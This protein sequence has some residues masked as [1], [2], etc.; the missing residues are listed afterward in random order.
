MKDLRARLGFGTLLIAGVVAIFWFDRGAADPWP[1]V[2]V[3]GLLSLAALV[4]CC[5]MLAAA[6]L[7]PQISA[8]LVLGALTLIGA[9]LG[10]PRTLGV[11]LPLALY[12]VFEVLRREPKLAVQRL[13]GT[14]L[15][16]A[17]VPLL[18]AEAI[19][20]R[21]SIPQGWSWL[22]FLVAVCKVGD[23]CAYLVGTAFGR[24]K[25]IPEVSPNKSW[26]GAVAS[27]V[28][29]VLAAAVVVAF[30]FPVGAAPAFVIW[31][32]AAIATNLGAQFGDLAESLIKRGGGIKNSS[33]AVP[34]FGGA[35]DMVDSFLLASPALANSLLLSGYSSLG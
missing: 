34:A 3:L 5:H 22:V 14:L 15:A 2:V 24:H 11:G 4:E 23:S 1:T 26:E 25:L 8:A 31:F 18:L 12:L 6:G 33:T 9:A 16:W 32:P 13:A 30:A 7:R 10:W 19:T 20:L 21:T 17:I 35:F 28:G 27:M 29:G